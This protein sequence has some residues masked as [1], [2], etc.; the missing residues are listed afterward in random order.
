MARVLRK[1]LR[2][3]VRAWAQTR[4]DEWAYV[5]DESRISWA[6]FDALIDGVTARLAGCDLDRGDRV[7]VWLPDGSAVHAAFH[8][9]EGAGLVAVGVGW[10]AGEREP[11]SYT[12]LTLPTNR[13]V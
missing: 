2:D 1:P 4:A 9:C 5:W 6:D 11:V 7:L 8:G 10:R 3:Y 12:H 13:E